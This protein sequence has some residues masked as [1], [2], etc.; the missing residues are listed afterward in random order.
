MSKP[1]YVSADASSY[2]VGACL[3]QEFDGKLH[4][5]AFASRALTDTEK[6]W[7]QIE[8]ECLALVWACEKF[9]HFLVGL[10]KFRLITDHKPLV[11]LINTKDLDKTPIRVQRLLIRLMRFNCICEHVPGKALVVA[12]ALSRSNVFP[13]S[14]SEVE[15]EIQAYVDAI[16]RAWPASDQKLKEIAVETARCPDL[17]LVYRYTQNGWPEYSKDVPESLRSYF[18]AR[19]CLSSVN[20]VLTYLNRIVI[21]SSLRPDTLARLH[22]GHQGI[23]KSRDLAAL[24]VWWPTINIDIQDTCKRCQF[25]EELKPSKPH[26]PL[27]PTPLPAG[28]WQK[29]GA[30]ICEHNKQQY[31]VVVDYYSRYIEVMHLPDLTSRTLVYKFKSLFARHGVPY[32]LRTD[33]ARSFNSEEFARFT[34][35]L[36]V[37][38]EFSSPHFSQSNGEAESAV[39]IAKKCLKQDDP[40]LALMMHRSTP[41]SSTGYS[42]A[43]LLFGRKMRI[44]VPMLS[45]TLQPAWPDDNLVREKDAYYKSS[46]AKY[47]NKR[48]GV[49]EPDN[50]KP[51]Q[52]VRIKTDAEKQWQPATVVQKLEK[53]RSYNV[54]T[55]KGTM[56]RRNVKHMLLS[57]KPAPTQQPTPAT[58]PV[59]QPNTLGQ[60]ASMTSRHPVVTAP[61]PAPAKIH[62]SP[63]RSQVQQR[64]PRFDPSTPTKHSTTVTKSG[65]AVKKP[66]KLDL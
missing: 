55:D 61:S 52:Q 16:E 22:A 19:S 48:H 13:D 26:A 39:K 33:N 30:D 42:P 56:L 63:T 9:S 36:D 57:Y 59:E 37:E 1:T 28:P 8:K 50:F 20:G 44:Q 10:P 38:H 41:H 34:S 31:L 17:S 62:L 43:E 15:S 14:T 51:N 27:M 58:R 2:G 54:V 40:F 64:Q 66:E 29:L 53:P 24:S 11:P 49:R 5:I 46:T 18:A 35:N 6:R 47:Y 25:C 65:R 4:P 7:A 32:C 23:T 3:M 21:P 60:Q 12:D 45:S